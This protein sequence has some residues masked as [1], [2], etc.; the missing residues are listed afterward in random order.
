MPQD[1]L[2]GQIS[3]IFDSL[4]IVRQVSASIAALQAALVVSNKARK[5][6][7][8]YKLDKGI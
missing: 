8:D 6:T 7:T 5:K 3:L 1:L 4:I 2:V